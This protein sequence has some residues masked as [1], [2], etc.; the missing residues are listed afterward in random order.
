MSYVERI[1]FPEIDMP[2]FPSLLQCRLGKR[3][4]DTGYMV[5]QRT[6]RVLQLSM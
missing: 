2:S 1:E 6:M 3:V 4:G 5:E